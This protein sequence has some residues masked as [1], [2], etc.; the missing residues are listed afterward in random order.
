MDFPYMIKCEMYAVYPQ[1]RYN[2]S[3]KKGIKFKILPLK[4]TREK[5]MMGIFNKL[6][7]IMWPSSHINYVNLQ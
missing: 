5:L 7:L 2:L 4:N 6:R 3:N 1:L